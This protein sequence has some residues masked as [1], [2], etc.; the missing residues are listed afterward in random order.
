MSPG[1]NNFMALDKL[2]NVYVCG[3]VYS[4]ATQNDY[5][6]TKYSSEGDTLWA[7][8]YDNSNFDDYPQGMDADSAGNVY[9]TGISGP[10]PHDILTVKYNASGVLQWAQILASPGNQ[11]DQGLDIKIDK[12]GNA[13]VAGLTANSSSVL[14]KYNTN[15]DSVWVKRKQLTGYSYLATNVRVDS[16]SDAYIS[17]FRENNNTNNIDFL[18][19]KYDSSGNEQWTGVHNVGFGGLRGLAIDNS[20]NS[21]ILGMTLQGYTTVK[22]GT[23]GVEQWTRNYTNNVGEEPYAIA[24]D[25]GGNCIV[26]GASSVGGGKLRLLNNKI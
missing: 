18:V 4:S 13:F 26:T 15:G 16:V 24:T 9:I 12:A 1:G 7:R 2:G 8:R 5:M 3:T 11:D 19:V 17:V 23:A 14:I 22:F 21:Y 6:L 25:A 20:G 10:G